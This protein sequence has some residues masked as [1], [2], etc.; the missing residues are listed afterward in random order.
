MT[1]TPPNSNNQLLCGV[2]SRRAVNSLQFHSKHVSLSNSDV[3][4][5]SHTQSFVLLFLAYESA[6]VPAQL[7][8]ITLSWV[9]VAAADNLHLSRFGAVGHADGAKQAA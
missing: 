8:L 6:V 3:I 4:L 7:P 2:Q 5:L 1:K 9:L